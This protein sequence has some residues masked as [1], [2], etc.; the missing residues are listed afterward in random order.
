LR[1]VFFSKGKFVVTLRIIGVYGLCVVLCGCG[2]KP[3]GQVDVYPVSGTL[4]V[5]GKPA[6]NA[7]V[8]LIPEGTSSF[9]CQPH[10]IVDTNGSFRLSTYFTHD[11]APAGKYVVTVVWPGPPINEDE[12]GPD[13]LRGRY[14]DPKRPAARV[15][16]ISEAQQLKP[17]LLK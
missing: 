9:R 15:Q 13:Q 17:I 7:V 4:F 11:G 10:A 6:I 5:A 3:S 8:T 14:S 2:S 12:D 1:P 16:I